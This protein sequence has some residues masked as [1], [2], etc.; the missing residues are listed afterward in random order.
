MHGRC[1]FG[2]RDHA[3]HL[4]AIT[5]SCHYRLARHRRAMAGFNQPAI[6]QTIK[7]SH[8]P[9]G[10]SKDPLR[11]VLFK[12]TGRRNRVKVANLFR[13]QIWQ[14]LNQIQEP[15]RLTRLKN[16]FR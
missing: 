15:R 14:I 10:R 12:I 8:S 4:P 13:G 2:D 3:Y 7:F 5:A 9:Q 16:F 6:D 11:R 1:F